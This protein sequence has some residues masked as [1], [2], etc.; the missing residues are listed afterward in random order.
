MAR[1]VGRPDRDSLVFPWKLVPVR[2]QSGNDM[3]GTA[4]A[5][6]RRYTKII[7]KNETV[8]TAETDE[9]DETAANGSEK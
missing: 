7:L 3:T 4:C 9:I 5:D 6:T 1:S 8:E 2:T